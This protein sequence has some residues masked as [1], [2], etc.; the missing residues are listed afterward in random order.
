MQAP[1]CEQHDDLMQSL[2]PAVLPLSPHPVSVPSLV[3]LPPVPVPLPPPPLVLVR[4]SLEGL[5]L[6]PPAASEVDEAGELSD[7]ASAASLVE[8][9]EDEELEDPPLPLVELLPPEP[10]LVDVLMP[11]TSEPASRA[12]FDV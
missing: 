10:E 11:C 7:D 4:A 5:V 2:H 3:L 8:V 12:R 1:A 6:V 9:P